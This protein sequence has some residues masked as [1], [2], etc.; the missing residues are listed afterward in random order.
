MPQG[1]I[2]SGNHYSWFVPFRLEKLDLFTD[3]AAL[4]KE[5]KLQ[6]AMLKV[7]SKFGANAL[8]TGKNL[9]KGA[10]NLERNK[11]IGGHKA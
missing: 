10:T 8:F 9:L 4:E 6:A 7:R 11:Q 3:Y 5:K 1:I 2:S